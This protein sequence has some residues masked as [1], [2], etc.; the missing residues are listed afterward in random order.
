MPIRFIVKWMEQLYCLNDS[1]QRRYHRDLIS[2]DSLVPMPSLLSV[3]KG[4]FSI[5][6]IDP[7]RSIRHSLLGLLVLVIW[8]A[9]RLSLRSVGGLRQALK[10]LQNGHQRLHRSH[11]TG[12][13]TTA[14]EAAQSASRHSGLAPGPVPGSA[15]QFFP[16]RQ[17]ADRGG[18]AATA[19]G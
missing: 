10:A 13:I 4:T 8:L 1:R 12:G 18:S 14:G 15:C 19:G 5:S 9:T 6:W 2:V 7:A 16:Q 3:A 11:C 17:D